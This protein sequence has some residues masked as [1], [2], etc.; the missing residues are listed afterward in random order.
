MPWVFVSK[1]DIRRSLRHVKDSLSLEDEEYFEN[2]LIGLSEEEDGGEET[3]KVEE[4]CQFYAPKINY[5]NREDV[6]N[7]LHVPAEVGVY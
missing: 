5:L 3:E 7:A 2:Y 1:D 4:N 6:R